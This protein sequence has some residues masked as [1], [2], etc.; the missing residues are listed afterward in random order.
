[1]KW[2]NSNGFLTRQEV[3]GGRKYYSEYIFLKKSLKD[4]STVIILD[5]K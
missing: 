5:L 4:C 1:M 2:K 3:T